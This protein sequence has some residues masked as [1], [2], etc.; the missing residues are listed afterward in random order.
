MAYGLWCW[1]CI[2]ERSIGCEDKSAY[3]KKE[4][5]ICTSLY[6]LLYC[7]NRRGG[8]NIDCSSHCQIKNVPKQKPFFFFFFETIFVRSKTNFVMFSL[9]L[10]ENYVYFKN[11]VVVVNLLR[12]L[13]HRSK[14]FC[15][16][17]LFRGKKKKNFHPSFFA[18]ACL[19]CWLLGR[20]GSVFLDAWCGRT[21]LGIGWQK[22]LGW[23]CE[24]GGYGNV[25]KAWWCICPNFL[26]EFPLHLNLF[27]L[28]F[29]K[30]GWLTSFFSRLTL[31]YLANNC[32]WS[33]HGYE[34]RG[35]L[36]EVVFVLWLCRC[37]TLRVLLGCCVPSFHM[38]SH[39]FV[40]VCQKEAIPSKYW[41]SSSWDRGEVVLIERG[42]CF[43]FGS[44]VVF[45]CVHI[46]FFLEQALCMEGVDLGSEL[47]V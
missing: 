19:S 24:R 38:R 43:F 34:K 15:G 17:T 18:V 45:V 7:C 32:M 46:Q 5:E 2:T 42:P 6:Q 33:C 10:Y 47:L 37:V 16:L 11:H 1:E 41:L 28:C 27:V 8:Q 3:S 21:R 39:F 14:H 20:E 9:L 36:L 4:E 13:T 29:S 44:S 23:G 30:W 35:G 12:L 25:W 31:W 22:I 26:L 40:Y